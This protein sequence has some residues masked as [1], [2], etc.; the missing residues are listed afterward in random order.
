MLYPYLLY[1]SQG[2]DLIAVQAS[3]HPN[4]LVASII[5][6][7]DSPYKTVDD[8]RGKKIASWRAG[9]PYMVLYEIMERKGWKEG[10]DWTY[11]N[12]REYRDAFLADEVDAFSAHAT[13]NI[14]A[15]LTTGVGR[16]IANPASDSIY[17]NGGGVTV[18][19]T[20][21]AFARD[22]P[23]ITKKYLELL[24]RT[25]AW[26]Y[27]NQDEAAAIVEKVTRAPAN[28]TKFGFRGQTGNWTSEHDLAKVIRET[29]VMQ[30]WLI[31]HG[32]LDGAKRVN[33][34]SLFATQ[35]F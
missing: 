31:D 17:V 6:K 2:A 27:A 35:Y 11:S 4:E 26:I 10:T 20:T 14:A 19:F 12:I 13:D 30:D 21:S 29:E 3:T 23:N 8:L 18:H 7:A 1:R 32:D 16:E 15:L 22:Y 24:D 25:Y 34:P 5:V 33:V 9:C 28:V